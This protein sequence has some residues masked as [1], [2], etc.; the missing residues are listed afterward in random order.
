[1]LLNKVI[2]IYILIGIVLYAILFIYWNDSISYFNGQ[3]VF[4]FACYAFLLWVSANMPKEFYT[5][6]RLGITVFVY[7]LFFVAMYILMSDYYMGNTFLFSEADARKYEKISTELYNMNPSEWISYLNTYKRWGADDWGAPVSMAI[8][9]K[10]VPSK[11][12][13][14]FCYILMNT[15][16]AICLFNIGKS[17]MNRQYAYMATISYSLSSYSLFFMGCG[18]K[19]EIMVLLVIVSFFMLYQFWKSRNL[20][21]LIAGGLVSFLIIFFRSP[22]AVF[23]WVAYAALLLSGTKSNVARTFFIIIGL[24]VFALA[25]NMIQYSADRYAN[26]GDVTTSYLFVKTSLFQKAVLYVGALIGPFP[27]LL[28]TG[29]L[30]T[31]KSLF[32][33]GLL[34]KFLLF[35]VFWK[36]FVYAIK[37]EKVEV[38]PLFVFTVLEMIGLSIALDGLELRKAMPH[39]PFYILS[40]FWFMDQYDTDVNDEILQSPYYVWTRRLLT[41]CFFI[42]FVT[43]L[44]WN[45]VRMNS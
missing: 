7:S 35:F 19:E 18:L 27:Q 24:S 29:E 14:N 20:L 9:L 8:M 30:L 22:V 1:M 41:V 10:I 4:T 40:A 13:I 16:G 33:S 11:L 36:G 44:V 43:T 17:I 34:L 15:I 2:R 37:A 6:R 42:V 28:Q 3:N 25:F 23:V 45:T 12:F 31:Y 32:G 26:G 5:S 21:Y 39:V 38:Y